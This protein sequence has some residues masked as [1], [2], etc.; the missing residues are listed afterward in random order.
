MKIQYLLVLCSLWIPFSEVLAK[1]SGR[2]LET[3]SREEA[4]SRLSGQSTYSSGTL[5]LIRATIMKDVVARDLKISETDVLSFL[6][7]TSKN[8]KEIQEFYSFILKRG[9]EVELAHIKELFSS[10][11][12]LN[13]KNIET[14]QSVTP[15]QLASL[16]KNLS[17]KEIQE[18]NSVFDLAGQMMAKDPH[19][20]A[21]N[22]FIRAMEEK[23]VS[24][25][26]LRRCER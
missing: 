10:W 19:L 8:N 3:R 6:Q 18:L 2:S 9:Q 14:F 17:K 1:R 4:R 24:A 13:I 12:V 26:K 15:S 7:N 16:I 22:A 25:E 23:G 20:K 21:E 11:L 5:G